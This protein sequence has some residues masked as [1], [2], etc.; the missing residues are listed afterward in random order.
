MRVNGVNPERRTQVTHDFQHALHVLVTF[1]TLFSV[2]WQLRRQIKELGNL[3][4]DSENVIWEC[5]SAFLSSSIVPSRL[6][7]RMFP[8]YHGM[9]FVWEASRRKHKITICRPVF[10]LSTELQSKSFHVVDWTLN[11][12]EMWAKWKALVQSVQKNCFSLLNKLSCFG[13]GGCL[14]VLFV[15][16]QRQIYILSHCNSLQC[17]PRLCSTILERRM[18]YYGLQFIYL[19]TEHVA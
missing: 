19:T 3:S 7:C 6:A 17:V 5:N 1:C 9:K 16:Y 4:N 11:G 2:V 8:Y 15:I 13:R 14:K 12:R 18:L 10:T